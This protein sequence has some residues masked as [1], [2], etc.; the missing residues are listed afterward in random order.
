MSQSQAVSGASLGIGLPRFEARS[1]FVPLGLDD[2]PLAP[3]RKPRCFAGVQVLNA[4]RNNE[5]MNEEAL[6]SAHATDVV[7][8]HRTS[9]ELLGDNSC[10]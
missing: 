9:S 6:L 7:F 8:V 3:F 2:L 1:E 5:R 4:Y 10:L